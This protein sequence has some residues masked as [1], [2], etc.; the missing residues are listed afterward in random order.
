MSE[1]TAERNFILAALLRIKKQYY[2][3]FDNT[4]E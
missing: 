1:K 2:D 3:S 4:I